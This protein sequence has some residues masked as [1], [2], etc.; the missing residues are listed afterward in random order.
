MRAEGVGCWDIGLETKSS[1]EI[2]TNLFMTLSFPFVRNKSYLCH[3]FTCVLGITVFP[4]VPI[5]ENSFYEKQKNHQNWE[6]LD[7]SFH[8]FFFRVSFC[9]PDMYTGYLYSLYRP[10]QGTVICQWRS[11]V[12]PSAVSVAQAALE[13]NT[14]WMSYARPVT[15]MQRSSTA[16]S[17]KGADLTTGRR[18]GADAFF[19]PC[20][21][22]AGL[23]IAFLRKYFQ[24][25]TSLWRTNFESCAS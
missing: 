23:T 21:T 9:L 1:Q 5:T 15:A 4:K 7:A 16:K 12:V 8:K 17:S 18:M 3:A 25:S 14:E 22:P 20:C 10:Q 13:G 19:S 6:V 11:A 24:W 2:C